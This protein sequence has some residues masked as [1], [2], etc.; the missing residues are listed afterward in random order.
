M[1]KQFIWLYITV[2]INILS[3]GMI[4]PLLPLFAETFQ[5]T[6][7]D[8]G[9][10]AMT[11]SLG[12][13]LTSPFWGRLS[14]RFGRKPIIIASVIFSIT[15]LLLLA[16][17]WNLEMIF[18]ARFMKGLAS[19]GIFP[20]AQAYIADITMKE[21]RAVYMGKISG[22]FAL[23]F[24]FGPVFGGILGT[25]GFSQTFLVATAI[26]IANLFLLLFFLPESLKKKSE[27]LV[28][29]EGFLNVKAIYHGLRGDFGTLF[30]LL[31]SW[32]FYISNYQV[33][34][35]LFAEHSFSMGPFETGVFFST[36]GL[37][38][39]ITQWVVLP[40]VLN[41]IG[42]Y[43]TVFLGIILMVVGQFL[44]PFSITV[45]LFYSIFIISIAGSGLTRPTVN[46][47]L[48]KATH[49]GQGTTMG[50]AFS[51]ESLGRVIGPLLA[52][53]S[54]QHFGFSSPFTLTALVLLASLAVFW[55]V[56]A[57]SLKKKLRP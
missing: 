26:S 57:A 3:F 49:E 34:V 35:P 37:V 24:L 31:F 43:R 12:Q 22:V 39:S 14:D 38:A 27:R 11:F 1:Q 28:L 56:E 52:G 36:T 20:I 6:P 8:I 10:I 33:A 13:L 45:F 46:A 29:R 5:A 16:S 41:F 51:F 55:N 25:Q 7:L 19:A 18:L 50:L 17:A 53:L 40:K 54:L 32:A 44:A 42:E 9:L 21:E 2:F 23:G 48:S 4:F 30:F 15:S 47:I